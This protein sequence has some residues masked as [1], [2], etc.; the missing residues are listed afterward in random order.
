MSTII[1][2]AGGHGQVVADVFFQSERELIGFFDSRYQAKGKTVLDLEILGSEENWRDYPETEF[3]VAIGSNQTRRRIFE[4]L[5]REGA[6]ITTAIHPTA[7]LGTAV[8]IGRGSQVIAGAIVNIGTSI[9]QNCIINTGC[10][11]DHHNL[12]GDHCHIAPG[13]NLAG[14]VTVGNGSF[15][16]IG[17]TVLPGVTIGQNV[18]VGAGA[19]VNR[20]IPDGATAVGVPARWVS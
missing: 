2:G 17:A 16:G 14:N 19:V 20:D 3:I 15:I 6:S 8:D 9:G 18:T 13:V 1:I 11:V 12:I 4:L 5:D 10:T 7:I